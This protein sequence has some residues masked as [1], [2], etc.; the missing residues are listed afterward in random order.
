MY[1]HHYDRQILSLE[2]ALTSNSCCT[3]RLLCKVSCA[4]YLHTGYLLG[5]EA[6][7]YS[8]LIEM[9]FSSPKFSLKSQNFHK[10][11]S[12]FFYHGGQF[13]H[14]TGTYLPS[15]HIDCLPFVVG[16]SQDTSRFVH[17]ATE[18][19]TRVA[20]CKLHLARVTQ[21]CWEGDWSSVEFDFGWGRPQVFVTA[22]IPR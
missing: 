6:V 12:K 8:P 2:S 7:L 4:K 14:R 13:L 9:A 21:P 18:D 17:F 19:Q 3:D 15:L 1:H 20:Q 22:P 11:S 5:S 10:M 16:G